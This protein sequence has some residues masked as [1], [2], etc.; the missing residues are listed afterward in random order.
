MAPRKKQRTIVQRPGS[1]TKKKDEGEGKGG[2]KPPVYLKWATV[3]NNS[4]VRNESPK[5]LAAV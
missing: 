4:E 3:E 5:Y 2:P 1:K